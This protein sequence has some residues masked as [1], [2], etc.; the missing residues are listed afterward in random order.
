MVLVDHDCIHTITRTLYPAVA[1]KFKTTVSRVERAIRHAIET[2]FNNLD[3]DTMYDIF[4][5]TIS[6][7]KGKPT[8]SHFIAA[9]AELVAEKIKEEIKK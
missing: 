4:G 5:N 7:N 2:S 8:N 3:P 9:M 6:Y 1:K